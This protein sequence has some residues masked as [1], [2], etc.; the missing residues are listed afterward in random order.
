MTSCMIPGYYV[1]EKRTL[2]YNE[3]IIFSVENSG[4][5]CHYVLGWAD[6]VKE[7]YDKEKQIHEPINESLNIYIIGTLEMELQ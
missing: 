1:M 5:L 6:L 2:V 3:L 4:L 7:T